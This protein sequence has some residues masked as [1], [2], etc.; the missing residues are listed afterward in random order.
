[1]LAFLDAKE[2]DKVLEGKLEKKTEHTITDKKKLKLEFEEIRTAGISYDREEYV[3]GHYCIG[4]PVFDSSKEVCAGLG[5]SGLVSRF[6]PDFRKK[7][8]Y[9]VLQCAENLSRDI[10][11]GGDI[12]ERFRQRMTE[13]RE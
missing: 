2:T 9:E 6:D 5:V 7:V 10:G 3:K 13:D 8:E 4:A 12:Y 11:Y 1:V